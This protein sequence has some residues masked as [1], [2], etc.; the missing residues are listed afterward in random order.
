[1]RAAATCTFPPQ[2]QRL[3]CT[4][5]QRRRKKARP[6][7]EGSSAERHDDHPRAAAP[8]WQGAAE[9]ADGADQEGRPSPAVARSSPAPSRR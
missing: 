6:A 1:M 4:H 5:A 3:D 7:G 9:G 2:R 8:W